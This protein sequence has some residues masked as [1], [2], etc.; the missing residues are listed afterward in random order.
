MIRSGELGA[1]V[2]G[3]AMG[4]GVAFEQFRAHPD[5][6]WRPLP[7][8]GM[9]EVGGFKFP[10]LYRKN[11]GGQLAISCSIGILVGEQRTGAPQS[12]RR[13]EGK[14][15]FNRDKSLITRHFW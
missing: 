5:P 11:R 9:Q 4:A 1:N 6:S 13:V 12:V 3:C 2:T 7:A 8:H 10:W 15:N 14:V